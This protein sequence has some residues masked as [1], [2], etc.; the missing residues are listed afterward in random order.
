[1]LDDYEYGDVG[2]SGSAFSSQV[3]KSSRHEIRKIKLRKR[4]TLKVTVTFNV[5]FLMNS[6]FPENEW[7]F[8]SI[9]FILPV[10]YQIG[11]TIPFIYPVRKS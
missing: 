6:V 11:E 5:A 3:E 10:K 1:M 7:R 4:A 9:L 2:G 8:Q